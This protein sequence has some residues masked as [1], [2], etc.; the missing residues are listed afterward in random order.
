MPGASPEV[1]ETKRQMI[2]TKAA[3]HTQQMFFL[4][5]DTGVFRKVGEC[6]LII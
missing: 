5:N 2:K 6:L 1:A 3:K 4:A